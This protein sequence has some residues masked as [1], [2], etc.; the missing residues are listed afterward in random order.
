MKIKEVIEL[1]ENIKFECDCQTYYDNEVIEEEKREF[2]LSGFG[3]CGIFST[4]V[5]KSFIFEKDYKTIYEFDSIEDF[6]E[7]EDI[8]NLELIKISKLSLSQYIEIKPG[9]ENYYNS[10]GIKFI[11]K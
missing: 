11:V 4:Y 7:N 9:Y 3:L 8:L 10:S 2:G 1:L 5:D 6:R